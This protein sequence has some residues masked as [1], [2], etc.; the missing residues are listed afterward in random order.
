ML[1]I[2]CSNTPAALRP[3]SSGKPV[4]GYELRLLNAVGQPVA[5]GAVGDLWVK[6][7]SAL[8]FYWRQHAKTKQTIRGEWVITGDRYRVDD[9]GFYW[10]EGRADDMIKIGGEWVSPIEIEH[11]LMAHPAVYES[12][13]VGVPVDGIMRIKAAI[14]LAADRQPTPE[15]TQ[16]LQEWCKTRLQRYQYPHIIDIVDA[17]PKTTTGKIQRFKL[18]EVAS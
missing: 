4:P 8:A 10:Y 3:G 6:G 15:L 14:V 13:V 9:D 2:F 16:E 1:H 17:L 12:A 5:P 7:D 18:R 11:A